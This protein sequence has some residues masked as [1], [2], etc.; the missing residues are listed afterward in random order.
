MRV[1]VDLG[2]Y[3][4]NFLGV[5]CEFICGDWKLAHYEE[6][7]LEGVEFLIGYS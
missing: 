6:L 3:V 1:F 5:V 4:L 2:F 7:D